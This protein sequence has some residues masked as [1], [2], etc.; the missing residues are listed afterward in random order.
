[1]RVCPRIVVVSFVM[2]GCLL[3]S[4]LGTA[5][6]G[7][8]VQEKALQ[9]AVA[10]MMSPTDTFSS[11]NRLLL[12]LGQQLGRE[13]NFVQRKTHAEVGELL[14][15]GK[16]DMAFICSG[17]YALDGADP[18][19]LLAMPV[20][21]GATTYH[22]YIIVQRDNPAK[23]LNELRGASFAFTDPD[24]NTG[25]LSAVYMLRLMDSEPRT[26]FRET[27]F[28]HSHDNSI[29]AVRRG[30]VDGAAVN[31]LIW[32]FYA[33]KKPQ[34]TANIRVLAQSPPF[35]MPPVVVSSKMNPELRA[36][37]RGLLLRLH[38]DPQG[39]ALLDELRIDRFVEPEDH[40]YTTIREMGSTLR[41]TP[42]AP[43]PLPTGQAHGQIVP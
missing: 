7:A 2:S 33:A 31:S 29:L 40:W 24:S 26:F 13:L 21:Q 12:Y 17:P 6:A 15:Q 32:D 39:R 41:L 30:L 18:Q 38:E 11:Y 27:M 10:P 35:A 3:L 28:T 42:A 37:L 34:L 5:G 4:S 23:S 16:L 8:T 19:S 36:A 9:V 22:S 20:V 14:R 1:M 25:Y 43:S